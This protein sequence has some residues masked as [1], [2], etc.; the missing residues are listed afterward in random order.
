MRYDLLSLALLDVGVRR[1]RVAVPHDPVLLLQNV[2]DHH[3]EVRVLV[4]V[5]ARHRHVEVVVHARAANNVAVEVLRHRTTRKRRS[6]H[7]RDERDRVGAG[8]RQCL[9]QALEGQRAD[10]ANDLN[11]GRV[12]R[13]VDRQKRVQRTTRGAGAVRRGGVGVCLAGQ[14]PPLPVLI[15]RCVLCRRRCTGA[16]E[17]PAPRPRD[18]EA[19]I[20]LTVQV[21]ESF[22]RLVPDVVAEDG[23][24]VCGDAC[25]QLAEVDGPGL[26]QHALPH[27]V[28]VLRRETV[29]FVVAVHHLHH[30]DAALPK[31]VRATHVQLRGE[32]TARVRALAP[33]DAALLDGEHEA[34][35]LGI[36]RLHRPAREPDDSTF[37][38]VVEPTPQRLRDARQVLRVA[39][40]RRVAGGTVVPRAHPHHPETAREGPQ[41]IDDVLGVDTA[42][43]KACHKIP[44]ALNDALERVLG[45]LPALLGLL[46]HG[47]KARN[48]LQR[49]GVLRVAQ[50]AHGGLDRVDVKLPQDGE[51][52]LA[53]DVELAQARG[54]VGRAEVTP[55]RRCKVRR[56]ASGCVGVLLQ[57]VPERA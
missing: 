40:T 24:R 29:P 5:K 39:R 35:R 44:C 1:L 6:H 57:K 47:D 48:N 36:R 51:N 38:H 49:R 20:Y 31:S 21:V 37:E 54:R 41:D 23:V 50:H 27:R 56:A 53:F 22:L 32:P 2:Q 17:Q 10:R 26:L 15:R 11:V 33:H 13:D 25:Q 14:Q 55:K 9:R 34:P 52:L 45:L 3:E 8:P 28:P 18:G 43:L 46:S 30:G 12:E 42:V 4:T 16:H 19:L 7:A